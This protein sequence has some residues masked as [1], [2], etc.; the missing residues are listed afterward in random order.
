MNDFLPPRL[1]DPGVLPSPGDVPMLLGR[2]RARRRRRVES[3]LCVPLV[4]GLAFGGLAVLDGGGRSEVRTV[5]PAAG[6]DADRGIDEIVREITG[7]TPPGPAAP[8]APAQVAA[9]GHEE[10]P[11]DEP[12]EERDPE[13]RE[14]PE[15]PTIRLTDMER[16]SVADRPLEMCDEV[17]AV[18]AEALSWCVRYL[19][20][21]Q[22]GAG[23]PVDLAL[24]YC[25][26][27]GTGKLSFHKSQELTVALRD[28]DGEVP[29]LALEEFPLRADPHVVS[30]PN[31]TCARWTAHW[32]GLD[33]VDGK[34]LAPGTYDVLW[35]SLGGHL[36][37]GRVLAQPTLVVV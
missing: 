13:D 11:E 9:G 31:G 23:E 10:E 24:E 15:E 19:G 7:G 5:E 1:P 28:A 29:W 18:E 16:V 20:P 8:P 32:D 30:V 3:A 33:F 21:D 37:R 25:A 4:A 22:A 36:P 14:D 2:A 34:P 6:P 17:S 26:R 12:R 35:L 27:G